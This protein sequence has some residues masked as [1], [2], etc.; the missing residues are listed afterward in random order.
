MEQARWVTPALAV[1]AAAATLAAAVKDFAAA[2]HPTHLVVRT[3]VQS[4]R[5]RRILACLSAVWVLIGWSCQEDGAVRS[6][7]DDVFGDDGSSVVLVA[8][9]DDVD[10][11]FL[12]ALDDDV[13]SV[14]FG[15]PDLTTLFLTTTTSVH[16]MPTKVQGAP[17]PGPT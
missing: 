2:E 13:C 5:R 12:G 17:L 6:L 11:E 14:V 1:A 9:H 4:R 15:G 16:K 7:A 3:L 10:V 8:E